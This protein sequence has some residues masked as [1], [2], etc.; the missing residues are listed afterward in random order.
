MIDIFNSSKNIVTSHSILMSS[1]QNHSSSKNEKFGEVLDRSLS[2]QKQLTYELKREKQIIKQKTELKELKNRLTELQT[3]QTKNITN[4]PLIDNLEPQSDIQL[5]QELVFFVENTLESLESVDNVSEITEI[6]P[7][8]SELITHSLFDMEENEQLDPRML[9]LVDQFVFVIDQEKNFQTISE[10]PEKYNF[11]T[12][13]IREVH[14]TLSNISEELGFKLSEDFQILAETESF[15]LE[16][17]AKE[18][19]IVI[20]EESQ[21]KSSSDSE[22]GSEHQK[23]TLIITDTR[24]IKPQKKIV[25]DQMEPVVFSKTLEDIDKEYIGNFSLENDHSFIINTKPEGSI[26]KPDT[27]LSIQK[28]YNFFSSTVSRV[29]VE[30]LM[31]SVSVKASILMNDGGSELRLKL[32]PPELGQMKLSFI[33]EDGMMTGKVVVETSEAKMF[34]EQNLDNLRESLANEG[35][36][37][38]DVSVELGNQNE[39]QSDDSQDNNISSFQAIRTTGSSTVEMP[40]VTNNL[41]D[42]L[43]DFIA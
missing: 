9:T 27:L 26:F 7:V 15:D 20:S 34:F 14:E 4:D 36:R 39:F 30:A 18:N 35:I 22:S 41:Q 40:K 2:E 28:S 6:I 19:D 1:K 17:T 42:S 25:I 21:P 32:T 8:L 3:K 11:I 10:Y 23:D 31:Q 16:A 24:S 13:L 43:V 33:S 38:V 37:L 12:N 5:I 29:Q